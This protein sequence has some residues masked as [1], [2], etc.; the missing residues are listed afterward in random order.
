MEWLIGLICLT[1]GLIFGV[2]IQRHLMITKI[3]NELKITEIHI[4]DTVNTW[5]TKLKSK[6]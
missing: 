6:L 4:V 5:W 1:C 2:Y 3:E